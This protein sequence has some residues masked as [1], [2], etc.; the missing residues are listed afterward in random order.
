MEPEVFVELV[1]R[2]KGKLPITALC[3]LFGISRATYYRWTHRK[4][5]GKLTP[6]EEAVRRL[7]F[8]HK[9]RYG[10][11]KITALINQEYKV[12]KNTVQKVMRK[13]H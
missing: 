5:L 12:N 13:Y 4:D 9:F 3:Q 8:Q 2:M 10:Y 11:R 7:C 1:K 6:L